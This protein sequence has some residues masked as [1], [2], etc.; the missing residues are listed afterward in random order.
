MTIQEPGT[1]NDVR[2]AFDSLAQDYDKYREYIIPDFHQFYGS[3][4]WAVESPLKNPRI[5]DIGAGTGLLSAF[6]LQKYPDATITLMDFAENMLDVA[7]ERFSGNE[8]I[9]YLV[10]DYSKSDLG[11]P[12]DSICSA[13]SIHHLKSEDKEKLFKKIY[14]S[15]VPGGIFVNA[16]QADGET[17][18]KSVV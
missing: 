8:N 3:A 17:D 9:R 18:R 2:K 14:T 12:F 6:L 7:R 16:D 4:V 11:G 5:L 15:L 10:S 13:L 1:M